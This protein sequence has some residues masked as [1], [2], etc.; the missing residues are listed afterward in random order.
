MVEWSGK[1][2]RRAR[3]SRLGKEDSLTGSIN[4]LL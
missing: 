3:E 4:K 1:R 2:Q